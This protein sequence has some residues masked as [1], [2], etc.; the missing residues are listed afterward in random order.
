MHL[1]HHT[2]GNI[3][4]RDQLFVGLCVGRGEEGELELLHVLYTS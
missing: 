3:N 1:L 2:N 4:V